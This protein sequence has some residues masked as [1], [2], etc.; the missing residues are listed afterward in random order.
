VTHEGMA[1]K[2]SRLYLL[3]EDAPSRLFVFALPQ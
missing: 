3:P 1:I 2:G